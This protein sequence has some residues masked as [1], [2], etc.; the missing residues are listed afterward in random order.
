MTKVS[1]R[2]PE[3]RH[4]LRWRYLRVRS[5]VAAQ[6]RRRTWAQRFYWLAVKLDGRPDTYIRVRESDTLR[7]LL[8]QPRFGPDIHHIKVCASEGGEVVGGLTREQLQ[9]ED[10]PTQGLV[11]MDA[12]AAKNWAFQSLHLSGLPQ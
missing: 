8:P 3:V 10:L 4:G 2:V 11:V 12:G 5:V 7:V 6:F 9:P 1:F